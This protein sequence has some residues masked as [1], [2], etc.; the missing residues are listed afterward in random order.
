MCT[1]ASALNLV[2]NR[3]S[4]H[5]A[6]NPTKSWLWNVHVCVNLVTATNERCQNG[7]KLMCGRSTSAKMH[8]Y[9]TQKSQPHTYAHARAHTRAHTHT[10]T[11][12]HTQTGKINAEP[13]A[14]KWCVQVVHSVRVLRDTWP[15][16]ERVRR[17]SEWNPIRKH[18]I[19]TL[20]LHT[21]H[22]LIQHDGEC[23]MRPIFFRLVNT[24]K[25]WYR[26]N[27]NPRQP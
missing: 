16:N 3:A 13:V 9:M 5:T 15:N 11:C 1:C 8:L 2:L 25:M 21:V 22:Q 17:R 14:F 19:P 7:R 24:Q 4:V 27:T 20:Q 10:H 26:S 23:R 12:A 6:S 18:R